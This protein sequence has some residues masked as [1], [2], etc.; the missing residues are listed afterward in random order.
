M[1]L[2]IRVFLGPSTIHGLMTL[3][4]FA[5]QHHWGV[6][7]FTWPEQVIERLQEGG[8]V[9]TNK[10]L[11]N[12]AVLAQLPNVRM[13][14]VA[15]TGFD[16]VD[17]ECCAEHGMGGG[18]GRGGATRSVPEHVIAMLFALRRNL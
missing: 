11:L 1:S 4:A 3:R 9:I 10:V 8:I 16:N 2:T 18:D 13:I 6:Y 14:A 17:V 12:Q 5:F 7:D 15:A